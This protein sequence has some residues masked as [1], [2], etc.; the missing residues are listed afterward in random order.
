MSYYNQQQ[1]P[2]GVPPP[3]G[4]STRRISEGRLSTTRLS[5]T[6]LSTGLSTARLSTTR[7]PSTLCSSVWSTTQSTPGKFWAWLHGRMFGCP[8]LLLCPGC[9]PLMRGKWWDDSIEV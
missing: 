6:R 8:V 2:V 5:T 9:L 4:L 7:I 3:Q 1:P